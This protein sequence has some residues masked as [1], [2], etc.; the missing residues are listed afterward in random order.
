MERWFNVWNCEADHAGFMLFALSQPKMT[1]S[2]SEI[3]SLWTTSGTEESTSFDYPPCTS[4]VRDMMRKYM[5]IG[6]HLGLI[7]YCRRQ[8]NKANDADR[9]TGLNPDPTLQALPPASTSPSP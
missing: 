6:K 4:Y 2:V 8:L 1:A 7:Q 9:N 3:Q 5:E